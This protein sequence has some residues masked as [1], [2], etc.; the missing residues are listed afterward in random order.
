MIT[1]RRIVWLGLAGVT[2]AAFLAVYFM[3]SPERQI[4]AGGRRFNRGGDQPVPTLVDTIRTADVPVYLDGVGT[5]RAL[6]TVIVKAQVDGKLV[7]VNFKEG[8]DVE[9]GFVL[10]KIDPTLYQAQY[11]QAVAKK[12]QD[13]ALLEN[14]RRDLERYTRLAATNALAT[15]QADT[16]KS[17]VAQY[18]AQVRADQAAIDN[19]RAVLE[20]TNVA[21]PIAGRTG[22]RLIDVGNIVR[23]ADAN[24]LVVITQIRPISILFTLPQQ[25]LMQ[26]NS[27][28][29]KRALTVEAF[30]ADNKTIVDR[31]TLTVVDNQV[32]QTTGTIK[33]KAEFPNAELQLWPGQFVNV[34]LLIETLS[35]AIV[36]PTS[37]VQ[38]GPNGPFLF[39]VREGDKVAMQPVMISQQDETR[40][41]IV[42]GVQ[43]GDRVATSSF[44]QLADGK[45]ISISPAPSGSPNGEGGATRPRRPSGDGTAQSQGRQGAIQ[46]RSERDNSNRTP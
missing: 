5:T 19:A 16:Q 14:A 39:V 13:E 36:A 33:L 11:D 23:A 9:R 35:Q 44:N 26:V 27:A 17:L 31:G 20:Y 6:N 15:Q 4:T 24:G 8:Q 1:V 22:L 40:T 7:A 42:S 21:A 29:A 10:A 32:D 34:R 38:R 2:L 46:R 45:Q 37:A 25:Q 30:G 41:V 18:E 28:F 43:P 12:A 3:Q